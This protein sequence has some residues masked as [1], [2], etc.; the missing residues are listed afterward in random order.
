MS[1]YLFSRA[2]HAEVCPIL[3]GFL[4]AL[5][6][7]RETNTIDYQHGGRKRRG[8]Q[9]LSSELAPSIYAVLA[10]NSSLAP[11]VFSR[12]TGEELWS[13]DQDDMGRQQELEQA[14]EGRH[15]ATGRGSAEIIEGSPIHQRGFVFSA[16][17][18]PL[19]CSAPPALLS[20]WSLRTSCFM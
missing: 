11:Q 13:E 14:Q 5:L 7:R 19:L 16:H 2:R 6:R 9:P 17:W 4:A 3:G 12:A 18:L 8:E 10:E 15:R 1:Y 20:R